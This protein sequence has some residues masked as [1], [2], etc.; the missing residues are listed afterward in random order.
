MTGQETII[1]PN[2]NPV[3]CD[4]FLPVDTDELRREIKSKKGKFY[5]IDFIEN[6]TETEPCK[7]SNA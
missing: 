2:R 4:N 6:T 5:F 3:L 1:A 7:R